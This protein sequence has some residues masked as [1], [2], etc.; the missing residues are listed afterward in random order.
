MF[1]KDMHMF[2]WKDMQ[3]HS[4][5]DQVGKQSIPT[6]Y[7]HN[8]D[9]IIALKQQEKIRDQVGKVEMANFYSQTR[10]DLGPPQFHCWHDFVQVCCRTERSLPFPPFFVGT[11]FFCLPLPDE[12]L[13]CMIEV[14]YWSTLWIEYIGD[15]VSAKGAAMLMKEVREFW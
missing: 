12:W 13:L 14:E 1:S 10:L 3:H 11:N 5:I 15:V 8:D 2:V 9:I 7:I 4:I 6:H